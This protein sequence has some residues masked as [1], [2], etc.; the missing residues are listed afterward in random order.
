MLFNINNELIQNDTEMPAL[1]KQNSLQN[2]G[3]E[4]EEPKPFWFGSL[5]SKHFYYR[6]SKKFNFY[7]KK[8]KEEGRLKITSYNRKKNRKLRITPLPKE[9]FKPREVRINIKRGLKFLLWP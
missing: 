9:K 5:I 6:Q 8:T 2:K 4:R 3:K 7:K 1:A